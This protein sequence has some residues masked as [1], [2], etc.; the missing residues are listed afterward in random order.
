MSRREQ[1]QSYQFMLQRVTSAFAYHDTDPVQPAGRRLMGAGFAGVMV[2]VVAIAAVGVFG[3]LRP[4]DDGG[5][6]DGRRIIVERPSGTRFVLRAGV[7]YPM[8]NLTS[9]ALAVGDTATAKVSA[10]ALRGV[11][12]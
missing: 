6:R 1:L 4:G 11:P 3:L 12:R 7:L 9:A 5:W 8:A 2:A 10:G